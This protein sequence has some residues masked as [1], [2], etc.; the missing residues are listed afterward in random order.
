MWRQLDLTC[1]P[2]SSVSGLDAGERW[3]KQ[4]RWFFQ[5]KVYSLS[6]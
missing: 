6:V 1:G 5:R 2:A 3:M 4:I